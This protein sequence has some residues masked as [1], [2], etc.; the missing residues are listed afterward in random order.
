MTD[1]N[2]IA[3]SV[4]HLADASDDEWA[5][6]TAYVTRNAPDLLEMLGMEGE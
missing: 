4:N 1:L 2:D 5:A 6:A 3:N